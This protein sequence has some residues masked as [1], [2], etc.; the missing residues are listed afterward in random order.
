[1]RLGILNLFFCA[2]ILS[3]PVFGFAQ[4]LGSVL[5]I[6]PEK[7][8]IALSKGEAEYQNVFPQDATH[9]YFLV[10]PFS[11]SNFVLGA[12]VF[13]S[14]MTT[15]SQRKIALNEGGVED[16]VF[17]ENVQHVAYGTLFGWSWATQSFLGL[18][19]WFGTGYMNN[20]MTIDSHK[21]A[22]NKQTTGG[23]IAFCQ[24]SS[25]GTTASTYSYPLLFG[26]GITVNQFGFFWQSFRQTVGNMASTIEGTHSCEV[27]S[28]GTN[29]T[30][31][32]TYTVEKDLVAAFTMSSFGVHYRF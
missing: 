26:L 10:R 4:S 8:F 14:S 27:V 9:S 32:N 13:N 6:G 29:F 12:T 18:Q 3:F 25:S 1:M 20:L 28:E 23:G 30:N 17:V 19:T 11:G 22:L 15:S 16:A 21:I 24:G 7:G 2:S 31:S 5:N